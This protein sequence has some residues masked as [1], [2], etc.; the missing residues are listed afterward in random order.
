MLANLEL[1]KGHDKLMTFFNK[2]VR[3]PKAVPRDRNQRALCDLGTAVRV[4]SEFGHFGTGQVRRL[5]VASQSKPHKSMHFNM[6]IA[7]AYVC[8]HTST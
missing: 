3:F 7:S 2:S 8:V 1:D 6:L 4:V 5:E